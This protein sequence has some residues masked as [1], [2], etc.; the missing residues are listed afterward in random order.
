MTGFPAAN[1]EAVSPPA[2][3]KAK[4]KLLAAN[5]TTG[6]IGI[7]IL[8]ISGLG[9]GCRFGSAVSIDASSHDPSRTKLPNIFNWE[10]VLPRSPIILASGNPVSRQHLSINP[11]PRLIISLAISSRNNALLSLSIWL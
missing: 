10:T 4:G 1:A 7:S 9:I 5:T 3:E 2:V 11:S 8:L 6:P